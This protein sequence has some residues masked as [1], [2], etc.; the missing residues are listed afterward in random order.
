MK[1]T[2][3]APSTLPSQVCENRAALKASSLFQ[4]VFAAYTTPVTKPADFS[5][6]KTP[7]LDTKTVK[8]EPSRQEPL[9]ISGVSV[10]DLLDTEALAIEHTAMTLEKNLPGSMRDEPVTIIGND[11][12][13]LVAGSRG[14]APD[15]WDQYRMSSSNTGR[16]N[17]RGF[18]VGIRIAIG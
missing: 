1:I 5:D 6:G 7:V 17:S 12:V 8:E 16:E 3:H 15:P 11:K 4:Q 14:K 10:K 18:Y 2:A 13:G 9:K